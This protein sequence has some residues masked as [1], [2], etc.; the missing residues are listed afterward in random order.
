MANSKGRLTSVSSS[1]SATNYTSFDA[2]G[3]LTAAT[4]VTDGQTYS[5]SYGYNPAGNQTSMTYPSGRVI[6]TGYDSA[7]RLAGVKDQGSGTYYAGSANTDA[8]NRLQ[9][10]AHGAVSVMKLGNGLW[11]HTDF[12]NRLQPTQIGLGTSSTDSSKVGL[13]YTYGTTN[14]NGNVLTHSYSGAGLSYTQTFGYDELNRLTT[15]QEGSSWSQTN[16][17]DRYGNRSV[18]GNLSFSASSNRITTSGYSYDDAGNLKNDPTQSFGFDAENKIKTVNSADVY[19]YDGDGNRVLKNFSGGSGEK[20]RMVYSGGQ[21]IAEY[22]L[23]NSSLK[24][25]YV[26]GAEGLI[27]T[28]EP[29][30]VIQYTTADHLGTP[31]VVTNSSA[32]VVSR[33]DYKPFGEEIPS[34]IGDRTPGIGFSVPDGVRQKFTSYERDNE[35]GLDYFGARYYASTQGRFTSPDLPFMDQ[36]ESDPQSWNLYSYVRNNPL[37]LIDPTGNAAE[38]KCDQICRDSRKKAEEW[39]KK[40]EEDGTPV[41]VINTK[42]PAVIEVILV[43]E[44]APLNPLEKA[45]A[46]EF[47]YESGTPTAGGLRSSQ[48][49]GGSIMARFFGKLFG[50]Q[51]AFEIAKA[52]G[53]HSGFLRNYANKTRAEIE[54]AIKSLER[55]MAIHRD[56]IANPAGAY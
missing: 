43:S 28:I 32:V 45:A 37:G 51:S 38:E 40:A 39:R 27:A 44:P 20:V 22:D 2:L 26:Y 13:S 46:G 12:N 14:N 9:Y 1:A 50:R 3:R 34:G 55:Q 5:M 30:A 16:S 48:R 52:G 15:S 36:W 19:R 21:L 17:Y 29:G 6:A 24:K 42:P 31:R 10:A 35:T 18:A 54:R 41:E 4:Q 7:G 47:P 53:K 49:I 23:T 11:E 8:T 33:H 56:K 25:E